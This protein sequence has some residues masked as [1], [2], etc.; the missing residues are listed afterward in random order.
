LLGLDDQ[1]V[2]AVPELGLLARV[3]QQD[4]FNLPAVQRGLDTMTAR[5]GHI[6][7]TRYQELK[8]R[9][10]HHLWEQHM[11]QLVSSDPDTQV[12]S[13]SGR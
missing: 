13:P 4:S 5:D 12:G 1:W 6:T 10:F 11:E 2:D 8:V 3:F 7:V 9:H